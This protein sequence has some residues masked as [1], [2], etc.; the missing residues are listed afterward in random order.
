MF[1]AA[2]R[3]IE[4]VSVLLANGAD[5]N[6]RNIVDATPI[7]EAIDEDNL[8]IVMAL[9]EAQ[10]HEIREPR[11]QKQ[12]RGGSLSRNLRR[13]SMKPFDLAVRLERKE[14]QNYL[15]IK[16]AKHTPGQT[17]IEVSLFGKKQPSLHEELGKEEKRYNYEPSS[18]S[19]TWCTKSNT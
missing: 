19:G 6:I 10:V 16:G 7:F 18:S 2:S 12:F 17:E 1:L 11:S 5:P 3:S 15:L 13:G 8:E 4:A 9:V 14:I